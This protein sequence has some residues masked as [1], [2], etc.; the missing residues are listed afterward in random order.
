LSIVTEKLLQKVVMEKRD[1][2]AISL[3]ST[4]TITNLMLT[5]WWVHGLGR[6]QFTGPVRVSSWAEYGVVRGPGMWW[7]AGRVWG[8]SWAGYGRW[9]RPVRTVT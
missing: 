5:G 4:P 6:G 7:F 1:M 3:G 2:H 8:G 9:F